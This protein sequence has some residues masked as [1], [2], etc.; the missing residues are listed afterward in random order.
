MAGSRRHRA[1]MQN[2]AARYDHASGPGCH[3]QLRLAIVVIED[4][5][6]APVDLPVQIDIVEDGDVVAVRRAIAMG[7][8]HVAEDAAVHIG[9]LI[10][11]QLAGKHL[12]GNLAQ[13][14]EE[15]V[16]PQR[17]VRDISGSGERRKIRPAF[18]LALIVQGFDD[19]GDLGDV[20]GINESVAQKK[21]P[22]RNHQTAGLRCC[23]FQEDVP[24]PCRAQF[25]LPCQCIER[26]GRAQWF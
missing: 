1:T 24:K 19:G 15:R 8:V 22:P 12:F 10:A 13:A 5:L 26:I 2:G 6:A 25:S 23:R 14:Q 7:I 17:G 18:F 21:L 11:Q 3:H 9:A 20:G 16:H 4:G